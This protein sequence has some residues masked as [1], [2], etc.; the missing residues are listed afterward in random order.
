MR[1]PTRIRIGHLPFVRFLLALLLG[2]GIGYAMPPQQ[3]LHSMAWAILVV[4]L[5]AFL[6]VLCTTRLR[7]HRYYSV[8]GFFALFAWCVVG[9]IM[10]W[11]SDP[12]IDR[13]HFSRFESKGLIGHIVD[14]P[15][16]HG[17]HVRF[18]FEVTQAY[19]RDGIAQ[20]AGRLMLTINRE[21]SLCSQSLNY[22]DELLIPTG[23]E[24]V[25]PPYNPGELD[26]KRF[27]AGKDIWHQDYLQAVELKKISTGKGNPLIAYALA[28]RQRMVV[29]FSAYISDKDAY[30][31]AS[32]LILG[33]RAELS[34]ALLQAFS[35]TGTIHVLSVSGMHVVIVFWLLSKLLWWM[36]R[37]QYLRTGKLVILL[38]AVWGY[39]LL[40]GF[41]PSILRA[42]I[43]I[44]FVMAASLFGQQNRVYNSIAASAFF[45]LLYNPKFIIDIGF[46]LSYLAVLGIVFLYPLMRA[47]FPVGNRLVRPIVEYTWMSV[48][49]QAGAGPLA[50]F[51]FH[52]FPVY[53]LP[54]NLL[55]VLPA[56]SIMYLGFG[57]LLVPPGQVASWIGIALEKLILLTNASLSYI[58]QL[59]L[60]SIGGIW[61][62][63]WQDA[64]IYIL[65]VMAVISLAARKKYGVYA[66]LGCTTLLVCSSFSTTL[67]SDDRQEIVLFNVR[68]NLAI[69]LV[70]ERK[71][72]LY[73]NLASVDDRTIRYSV[74]PKLEAHVPIENIHF[75]PQDSNY[76]DHQLYVKGGVIQFDNTRLL[77]YDGTATYG[78]RLDVD[79]L[80]L[81][82]NP[83]KSLQTLL[84]TINCRLL[85]LDGSNFDSTIDR[86]VTEAGALDI[87]VYVLKDNFAYVWKLDADHHE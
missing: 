80:V 19:V 49:A 21:N 6:G 53:F 46:Q 16:V 61:L 60:A 48:G 3:S 70:D 38:S 84:A 42:T 13:L 40:T 11:Q 7:Q 72:W 1:P 55:I 75:I 63:W 26:Y 43:M 73:S 18:P 5:V 62:T 4:V 22:G 57:L 32:T 23:Y 66:V 12:A 67:Q 71:V 52:Q 47:A 15:V 37:H 33:Y 30:S 79:I 25:S 54:A 50:A 45:L 17:N 27:L 56:S 2:I 20:V 69:G 76:H 74:L 28:L 39:A 44:S 41:S 86:L 65:I 24:E 10:V 77:V 14:E 31:V 34:D 59:P 58:E 29:K 64:L 51:Y 35:N 81:R 83:R 82:N 36:N 87:P 68:R 8:L 78:G 9:F 85:L